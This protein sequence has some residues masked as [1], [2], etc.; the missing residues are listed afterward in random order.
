V[1]ELP[2]S[3]EMPMI[4]RAASAT[5]HRAVLVLLAVALRGGSAGVVVEGEL[6]M[7]LLCGESV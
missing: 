5:L 3:H 6:M 1:V 7:R 2:P 4:T